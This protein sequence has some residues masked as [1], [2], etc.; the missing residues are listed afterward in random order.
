MSKNST[1][2]RHRATPARSIA[3]EGLAV[4][5]KSLGRPALAVAAASG[6]AFGV[7]APAHAGVNGPDTTETASVQASA[8]PAAA[9]AAPAAAA[10][11]VHTVVSGDTL[12]AIASMHGVSL[13]DVLSANGLSVSTIIYPGDQIQI[14]AAGSAPAAPAPAYVAPAAAPAPAPVQTAAVTT[15]A[16]T[17]MNMSY[18]SAPVAATG[19]GAGAA[20]LANAYGQVG[21]IQDCTAMVEKA[22]RTVGKSVGDLAPGQFYQYGTTVGTP[23]PGDLVITAGHVGVYAGDGQVVSGGVNG[24]QTAVHSISW[25]SGASFVRV[26]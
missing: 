13:N 23:A 15:P 19:S 6:I 26:A 20:I 17:G 21:Q 22:L 9:V 11:N 24:N 5:A 2:A 8:A 7:G 14:P 3:I 4:S 12:G 18:A 16:N 1:T 10:G 25:L